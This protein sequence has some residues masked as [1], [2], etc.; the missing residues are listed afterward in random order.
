[1]TLKC[2]ALA[3]LCGV[4]ERGVSPLIYTSCRSVWVPIL[5][6]PACN[7]HGETTR[8]FHVVAR[9]E[10]HEEGAGPAFRMAVPCWAWAASMWVWCL[11]VISGWPSPL[12]FV[13]IYF[14]ALSKCALDYFSIFTEYILLQLNNHQN[15]SNLLVI[16]PNTKFGVYFSSFYMKIGV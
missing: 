8:E 15:S 9:G 14:Y 10:R 7:H 13:L 2:G 3:P 6:I 4:C 12:L 11:D 16:D 1:M 5:G